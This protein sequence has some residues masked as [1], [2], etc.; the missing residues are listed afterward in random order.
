MKQVRFFHDICTLDTGHWKRRVLE[1]TLG[2]VQVFQRWNQTIRDE[3]SGR[4]GILCLSAVSKTVSKD[5]NVRSRRGGQTVWEGD[6][7]M[8]VHFEQPTLK[9][10][11]KQRLF[12]WQYQLRWFVRHHV[13]VCVCVSVCLS[14]SVCV[15]VCVWVIVCVCVCVCK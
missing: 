13:C 4:S 9:A 3:R 1:V 12:S 2:N 11:L 10:C 6:E 8:Y 14:F 15:C 7:S 5:C